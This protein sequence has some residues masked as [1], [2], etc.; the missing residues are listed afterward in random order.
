VKAALDVCVIE[1]QRQISP[2]R[3]VSDLRILDDV[4]AELHEPFGVRL[5]LPQEDVREIPTVKAVVKDLLVTESI[6]EV[7]ISAYRDV[8]AV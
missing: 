6:K 1:A 2:W 7:H 5:R 3:E 4:Q 8:R